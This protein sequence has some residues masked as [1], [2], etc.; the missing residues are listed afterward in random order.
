MNAE[1]KKSILI[2]GALTIVLTS[3]FYVLQLLPLSE[4]ESYFLSGGNEMIPPIIVLILSWGLSSIVKD[5]GFIDFIT[6]VVE[7][8]I[9]AFLIPAVIFLI[10]KHYSDRYFNDSFYNSRCDHII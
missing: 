10:I 5:M 3:V 6:N 1:F 2:S 9:P 7:N 4:I 8:N